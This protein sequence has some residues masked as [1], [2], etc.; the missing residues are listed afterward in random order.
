MCV[1][2]DLEGVRTDAQ[3]KSTDFVMHGFCDAD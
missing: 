1:C 3:C 2:V